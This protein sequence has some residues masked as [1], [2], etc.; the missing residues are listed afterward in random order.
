MCQSYNHGKNKS[1]KKNE[2][3]KLE[4]SC[5]EFLKVAEIEAKMKRHEKSIF[6]F[7]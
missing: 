4:I 1:S 7:N 5:L 3:L 2:F 6:L